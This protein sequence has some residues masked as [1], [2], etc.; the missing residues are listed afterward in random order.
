LA[1]PREIASLIF[2]DNAQTFVFTVIAGRD[3]RTKVI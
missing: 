1:G 3:K 2:E